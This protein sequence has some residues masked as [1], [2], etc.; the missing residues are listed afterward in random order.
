[1][2]IIT[3]DSSDE[4]D[5]EDDMRAMLDCALSAEIG[6]QQ[7]ECQETVN[8]S[9]SSPMQIEFSPP[10][11]KEKP[12]KRSIELY[13]SA[14]DEEPEVI[15]I[16]DSDEETD[17]K[18]TQWNE[19]KISEKQYQRNISDT[20]SGGDSWTRFCL[21]HDLA[22]YGTVEQAVGPSIKCCDDTENPF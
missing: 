20:A 3:L 10:K 4:E 18:C 6:H 22:V 16:T 15:S 14:S 1:M 9:S 2:D 7:N 11:F 21:L 19:H 17:V 8:S 13:E 5:S 12:R